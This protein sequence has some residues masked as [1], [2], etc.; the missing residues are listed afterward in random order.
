M[1]S[2]NNKIAFITGA[3]TGIGFALSK[4]LSKN[5]AKVMMSDVNEDALSAAAE[6]LRA[7]GGMV[8]TIRCDVANADDIKAAAD[9]T[10]QAFGKVHILINNAGVSLS[11][12]P[13]NIPLK[14]WRWI[15]DINLMS[16]L[17]GVET[18]LPLI[19]MHDEGGYIINTSSMS[20]IIPSPMMLPYSTTKFAVFGYTEALRQALKPAGIGASVLCPGFVKTNLHNAAA[21]RPSAKNAAI[22]H[23]DKVYQASKQLIENGIDPDVV[24]ELTLKA[25]RANRM[26]IFT[27]PEMI[28][29]IKARNEKIL[30]NYRDCLIDLGL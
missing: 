25:M 24:A 1:E 22:D 19:R 17:F 6:S 8:D 30:E 23:S 7:N 21:G 10:I 9:A 15:V 29:I 13:G 16:V 18:F 12:M 5:G 11:G 4:A 27:D 14:D 26:H 28:P 20:G 3:A 2:V